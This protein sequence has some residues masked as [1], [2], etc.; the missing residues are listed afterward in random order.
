VKKGN[1]TLRRDAAALILKF[2][3]TNHLSQLAFYSLDLSVMMMPRV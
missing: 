2:S 1:S 3:H